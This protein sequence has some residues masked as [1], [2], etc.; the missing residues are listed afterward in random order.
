MTINLSMSTVVMTINQ[1]DYPTI[2]DGIHYVFENYNNIINILLF[3]TGFEKS[4]LPHTH[5][6]ARHT[7]HHHMIVVRIN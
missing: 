7:F 1:T 2:N 6:I 5:T 3:V 4:W